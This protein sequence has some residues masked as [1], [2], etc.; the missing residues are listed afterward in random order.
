MNKEK[1]TTVC[2]SSSSSV[3]PP[4]HPVIAMVATAKVTGAIAIA[5][6]IVVVVLLEKSRH[7]LD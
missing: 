2:N 5:G 7:R 6:V 1:E 3:S 4:G